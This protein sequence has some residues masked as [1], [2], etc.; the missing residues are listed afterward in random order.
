MITKIF[1][2]ATFGQ[3]HAD[4]ILTGLRIYPS[5]KVALICYDHDNNNARRFIK[6]VR[7]F[8]EKI[9]VIVYIISRQNIIENVFEYFGRVV[10]SRS[11]ISRFQRILVNLSSGDKSLSYAVLSAAYIKGIETFML[12]SN[13]SNSLAVIPTPKSYYDKVMTKTNLRILNSIAR[14]GDVVYGLD[15]LQ[16]LSGLIKSLLSYHINGRNNTKGLVDLGLVRV[17]NKRYENG[18]IAIVRLTAIG[19]L[20]VTSRK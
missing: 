3:F 10:G 15:Q 12:N 4:N 18:I 19:K 13:F 5:Q 16:R 9:E 20:F 2:V 11:E 6:V 1:Q 7:S 8:D 14:A 17:E